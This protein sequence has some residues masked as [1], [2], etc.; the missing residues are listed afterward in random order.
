M[1]SN[2]ASTGAAWHMVM[3]PATREA[4]SQK[5]YRTL[6]VFS[7]QRIENGPRGSLDGIGAPGGHLWMRLAG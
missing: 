7:E 2:A 6:M 1:R 3:A 4:C 5:E